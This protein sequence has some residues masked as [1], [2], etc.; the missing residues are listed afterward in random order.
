MTDATAVHEEVLAFDCKGERLVGIVSRPARTASDLAV[1]VV[2]GGPQVRTGGH[3][4]FTRLCRALGAAGLPALRFD[5]RGM[6]DSSGALHAF[7]HIDDDIAAAIGALQAHSPNVRRMV[8]W[9]LCDGASAALMYTQAQA[10]PR[11]AGLVMVNPWV[12]S[13]ETLARAHVKHYYL[14]R[15]RQPEFWRKLLGGGVASKALHDLLG[16]LRAAR[17]A[18]TAAAAVQAPPFQERM[19]NGAE[20]FGGPV[21]WVLSGQDYTAK[22]FLELAAQEP[23]WQ[24]VLRRA[25]AERLDFADADHTFSTRANEDALVS[26]TLRWLRGLGPS[27][28]AR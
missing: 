3:R 7:E 5:V 14:N 22:E 25:Q 23:R 11:V 19:L 12:R 4:Q 28:A 21:L 2:V 10:D 8:L 1:L 13:T 26:A 18:A 9:G 6:G 15:L 27:G 17:G 24:A 20:G 16:N